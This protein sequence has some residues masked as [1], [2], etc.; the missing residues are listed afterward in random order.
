MPP[1]VIFGDRTIADIA[2]KKPANDAELSHVYG[3]GSVKADRF[4]SAI[5]RIVKNE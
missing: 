4:G 5:I 3:I 1:Y 2:A